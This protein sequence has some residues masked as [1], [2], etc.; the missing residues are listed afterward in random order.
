MRIIKE[1]RLERVRTKEELIELLKGYRGILNKEMVE[2]LES[3][4]NLEFS[5]IKPNI[6]DEDRLPLSELDIYREAATYNIYERALSL[7][8]ESKCKLEIYDNTTNIEGV[9]AYAKL[10][11]E[12]IRLYRFNYKEDFPNYEIPTGYKTMKIGNIFIYQTVNSENIS[13]LE[14]ERLKEILE[15]EKRKTSPYPHDPYRYGGPATNWILSHQEYIDSLEKKLAK[16]KD[17]TELTFEDEQKIEV[18]KVYNDLL[19]DDYGLSEE[20][21]KEEKI[22]SIPTNEHTLLEKRL[23]KKMPNIKIIKDIKYI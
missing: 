14:I 23:I 1:N 8:K 15:E 13:K 11:D 19:L 9:I 2:Y 3:I 6:T 18:T 7:F 21:L 5:V 12:K 16:L 10:N 4:I 17:K 20:D 22:K